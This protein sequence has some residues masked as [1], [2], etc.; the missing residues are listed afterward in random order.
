MNS[1]DRY[2]Q[3]E[4]TLALT[5][6]ELS[7]SEVHGTVVG[8]I[9]NHLKTGLTPDLLNCLLYTSPSPRD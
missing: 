2:T 9:A 4:T 8:A 6:L 3:V 1:V 5:G 7:V